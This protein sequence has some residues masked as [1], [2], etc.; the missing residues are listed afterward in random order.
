[1]KPP[2]PAHRLGRLILLT[3]LGVAALVVAAY[4]L[5]PVAWRHYEHFKGLEGR[6]MI[7]RTFQGIPGDPINFGLV[8]SEANVFC[9]FRAAGWWAANPVT[10]ASS[11]KIAGSVMTHRR[12][13]AAP[14]SPLYYDGR[15]EDLAFELPRGASASTRHHVRLWRV[16]NPG[17]PPGT[18]GAPD[19]WLGSA[20]FDRGVGVSR[21]TLRV[22]HHIDPDLDAERGFLAGALAATRLTTSRYEVSGAGPTVNG[23][24]GGG[25]PYFTDGEV[26][27]EALSPACQAAA[28]APPTPLANPWQVTLKN[29]LWRALRPVIQGLNKVF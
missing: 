28:G 5:L 26:V 13:R 27:I 24:N 10:L 19:V 11:L 17:G 7:T 3:A 12:Y 21:Y 15:R 23:R 1:M 25:D 18:P 4:G 22:T 20:S 14:V 6:P 16:P 8:G 29:R 2:A 9:A